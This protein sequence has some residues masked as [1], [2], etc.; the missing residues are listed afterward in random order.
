MTADAPTQTHAFQ[1]ETRQLLKLMI[2][3]L[4]S[5]KEIFLRELISNASDACD[6]L[7]FLA[8]KDPALAGDTAELSVELAIDKDARTLTI[9]DNGIGM[10]RQEVIDN[11]G[12]IARSGTKAFMESLSGDQKKDAQLI[13]QFGVG[14][15]SAFIVADRVSVTTRRAGETE[16]VHWTSDGQ[17]EY[18]LEP[19]EKAERGTEIV[20]HLRADDDEFLEPLRIETLVRK[21]SDHIGLPILLDGK[22]I[23]QASA[24]WTRPKADLKDEEYQQFYQHIAHDWEPPLAWAHH[25]VEGTLE[26]TSL[27]FI[28][29]RAPFDL[30]DREQ[31]RGVQ[32]YVKRVFIMDASEAMLP[33]YLRFVRGVVDSDDLPLNVSRELLQGNRTAEKL[34]SAL[35][36]RVLDLLDELA[37]EKPDDY[38]RFFTTFGAVLK[39]GIVEDA[40]NRERIAKLLRF[41]STGNDKPEVSLADYLARKPEEQKSIYF[42]SAETLSAARGSPHLEGFRKKGYEVL[43]LTD[44]IDEWVVSHLTEFEGVKL[45]SV[46]AA[47]ED[48][49]SVVETADKARH[50]G[51]FKDVLPRLET[52]LKDRVASVRLTGRLIESPACLVAGDAGLSRRLEALLRQSG[53][54][55]PASK[56]VFELN[57]EHPLVQRLKT[58]PDDAAFADLAELLHGQAVLAEGGQLDD[59]AG[60][61]KRL[62]HLVL[63]GLGG[64][65]GRILLEG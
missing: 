22:T 60:F 9:R 56:P 19:A 54:A 8:L 26:Y 23:N 62:N 42:L 51:E 11:L 49:E 14:F 16:A 10:S 15:Y 20:L 63:Q 43:L 53:Q 12:T 41:A 24:L 46:A 34:K 28:P 30:W 44:R 52:L 3:S 18:T 5:N 31:A 39:E 64:E 25:K 4:Y 33:N 47:G 58:T 1:A 36:K 29:Q 37:R 57:P 40:A 17:G 59:P 61:V 21:Y 6:K 48:V 45:V 13:G 38:R 2:H 65:G 35:T 32:L 7:R 27:L 55:M 50:E